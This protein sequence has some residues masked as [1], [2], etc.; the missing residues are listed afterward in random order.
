MTSQIYVIL[1]YSQSH[2][3]VDKYDAANL[4]LYP[5]FIIKFL[6]EFNNCISGKN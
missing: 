1:Y 3:L 4:L 5:L 2:E 6:Y